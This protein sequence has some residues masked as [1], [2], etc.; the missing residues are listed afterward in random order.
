MDWIEH[1]SPEKGIP[2]LN[3]AVPFAGHTKDYLYDIPYGLLK[4]P[5]LRHDVPAL[6][7]AAAP[8]GPFLAADTKYGFRGADDTLSVTLLRA[9]YDPDPFPELGRH[10]FNLYVGA[11]PEGDLVRAAELLK[12][13]LHAV[14]TPA[15]YGH[16]PTEGSL[17]AVSGPARLY[18]VK[19]AEEE[20]LILRLAGTADGEAQIRFAAALKACEL[21][22]SA[23]F[24]G[25]PLP[26][27]G[28]TV[29]VPVRTGKLVTLRV[30][31]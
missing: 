5:A 2:Q 20:G 13:P 22:D 25:T 6:S 1:G 23:E 27:E 16:L 11:A 21:T 28:D 3:F 12:H 10:H 24:S 4:R 31:L 19:N 7:L 17:A 15:H 26:V 18:A 30:T 29:N 8:E 9:S 14:S